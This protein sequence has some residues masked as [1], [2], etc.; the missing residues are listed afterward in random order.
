MGEC[1]MLVSAG[2]M[3]G[4]LMMMMVVV[5]VVVVATYVWERYRCHITLYYYLLFSRV[6]VIRD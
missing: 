4:G 5:V 1:V 6:Q 2:G 3:C